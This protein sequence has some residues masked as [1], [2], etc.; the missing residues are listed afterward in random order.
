VNSGASSEKIAREI[1][2]AGPP[3]EG[4]KLKEERKRRVLFKPNR[5][6]LE[7]SDFAI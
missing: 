1:L 2:R 7:L 4:G 6:I 3:G 5:S